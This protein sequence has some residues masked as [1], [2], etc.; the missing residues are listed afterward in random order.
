MNKAYNTASVNEKLCIIL[1]E[2]SQF[3]FDKGQDIYKCFMQ[4]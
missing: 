4:K 2:E 1:T 3:S